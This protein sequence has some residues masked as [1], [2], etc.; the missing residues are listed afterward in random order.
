[1]VLRTTTNSGWNLQLSIKP[2]AEAEQWIQAKH[3]IM[4][5]SKQKHTPGDS[6]FCPSKAPKGGSPQAWAEA[7][8]GV[9]Q[10][11]S[12]K[13]HHPKWPP[14]ALIFKATLRQHQCSN[15]EQLG[16]GW[17]VSFRRQEAPGCHFIWQFLFDR[18]S[19]FRLFLWH[20]ASTKKKFSAGYRSTRLCFLSCFH[21]AEERWLPKITFLGKI[22]GIWERFLL[23]LLFFPPN[24]PSFCMLYPG[25]MWHC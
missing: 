25:F 15:K 21:G 5:L 18:A 13:S 9:Q 22:K 4:L 1:M 20:F 11:P 6:D 19:Y 7:A 12:R 24:S 3:R 17:R 16:A 23:L 10:Y 14:A 8:Q 2:E